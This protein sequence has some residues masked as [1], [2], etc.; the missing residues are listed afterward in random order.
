MKA[1]TAQI[2]FRIK[3]GG[4]ASEQYEEQ[5]RLLYAADDRSALQE[6]R[7]IGAADA[8]TFVDR[9]GR[10]IKWE[11]VAIKDLQPVS[12]ENGS[13]LISTVKEVE[14]VAAPVWAEAN[15]NN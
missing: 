4:V 14:P 7:R 6:A 13:L 15:S 1:Y 10:T 8:T 3:C 5:W 9:H 11:L 12:L 2:I